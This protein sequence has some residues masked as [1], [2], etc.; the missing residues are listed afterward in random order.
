MAAY[1]ASRYVVAGAAGR[2]DSAPFL[3]ATRPTSQ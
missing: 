1:S 2:L 3:V